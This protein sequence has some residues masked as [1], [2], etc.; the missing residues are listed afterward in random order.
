MVCLNLEIWRHAEMKKRDIKMAPWRRTYLEQG[1]GRKGCFIC[2]ALIHEPSPDT[3]VLVKTAYS[4]VML[5]RYPY[6]NGHLMIVPVQH[7]STLK[8]LDNTVLLE[9]IAWTR[10]SESILGNVYHPQGFNV[11]MNLGSAAGA[12]LES[13]LHIHILPR[14]SGDTN[15][16]TTVGDIR[17]IPETLESTWTRL[18]EFF[19]KAKDTLPDGTF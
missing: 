19:H 13:H 1:S 15:F 9:L 8:S 18:T 11:G 16:M 17:V 5:N 4:A 10:I 2:D 14:W 7:V 12:G 3:L 6:N